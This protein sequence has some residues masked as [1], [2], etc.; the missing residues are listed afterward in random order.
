M[1]TATSV[2][3]GKDCFKASI[4][5]S[6]SCCVTVDFTAQKDVFPIGIF[7]F[8]PS[9]DTGCDSQVCAGIWCQ[10]TFLYSLHRRRQ[11]AFCIQWQ[12]NI[13]LISSFQFSKKIDDLHDQLC[14]PLS[15]GPGTQHQLTLAQVVS[16]GSRANSGFNVSIHAAIRSSNWKLLT[17]YPGQYLLSPIM[18]CLV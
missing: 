14:P 4:E 16:G 15:A 9:P 7:I 13:I 10:P 3:K 11:R 6:N 17:G 8:T 12:P 2:L 5:P 1:H 18:T